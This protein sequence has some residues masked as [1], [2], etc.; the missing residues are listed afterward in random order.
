MIKHYLD[1]ALGYVPGGNCRK[2]F[3]K[4]VAGYEQWIQ[5]HEGDIRTIG[6]SGD[7]IEV[8]F[9][10]ILKAWSTN[11]KVAKDF[12][13]YLIPGRSVV[14]QQ[15]YIHEWCPWIHVT[16]ELFAPYFDYVDFTQFSSVVYFLKRRIPKSLSKLS[17]EH[18]L[19]R[20]EK[21]TLMDRAVAR[22]AGYA[23]GVVECAKGRLLADLY[24]RDLA[25]EHLAKVKAQYAGNE[26]V[27]NT[28]AAIW[29]YANTIPF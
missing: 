2:E 17:I 8:L 16:M 25:L 28:L 21:I 26:H 20:R 6:W 19:T 22:H 9:L 27:M 7:P 5:V 15:D 3:E 11:E 12:F 23:R 4:V 18:D 24:G 14:I 10:D 13:P 29:K 1:A